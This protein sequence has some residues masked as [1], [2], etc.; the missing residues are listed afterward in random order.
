M[1][2]MEG[3]AQAVT[4]RY[5]DNGASGCGPI[6]TTYD[7]AT[8]SCGSGSA[9]VYST[10]GAALAVDA[11]GDVTLVRDGTYVESINNTI[12]SGQGPGLSNVTVLAGYGSER[13]II[14]PASYNPAFQ[15]CVLGLIGPVHSIVVEN[16]TFD[17]SGCTNSAPANT[18]LVVDASG[19]RP[20]YI[21]IHNIRIINTRAAS[22]ILADMDNSE[23]IDNFIYRNGDV[24]ATD[25]NFMGHGMY[26]HSGTGNLIS[27][28]LFQENAG[29]G[30][31]IYP[32]AT[33]TEVS[34]N[35]FLKNSQNTPYCGCSSI[36]SSGGSDYIHH[37][38]VD[39]IKGN[40]IVIEF[41]SVVKQNVR[42]DNNS[43]YCSASCVYGI[44]FAS[45]TGMMARNNIIL[46]NFSN[47]LF[48]G[49]TN[50]TIIANLVTGVATDIWVNPS[51]DNFTLKAASAAID[52]AT[53]IGFT[54]NGIACDQGAY[55][56]FVFLSCQVPNG[57]PSTIQ[58]T[59][60][61]DANPPLKGLTIFT[62]RRNGSS[63]ALTGAASLI[64]DNIVS[65]PVTTVYSIGNTADISWSSGM[66]SDSSP[67]G[68]SFTAIYQGFTTTLSNQSC[69]NNAGVGPAYTLAQANFELHGLIGSE[70]NPAIKPPGYL[71]GGPA[72]NYSPY[73]VVQS[74][75]I[76][77]RFEIVANNANVPAIGFYLYYSKDGAGYTNVPDA[78]GAD[79]IAFCGPITSQSG[80]VPIN[81]SPT[82]NQMAGLETFVPGGII[83]TA[84]AIPTIT[85]LN[86]GYKTELEYCVSWN[87]SATGSYKLRVYQQNGTPLD[88]YYND[89]T[90]NLIPMQAEA[91]W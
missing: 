79:G 56:S 36:Q 53:N 8:R 71:P 86:D 69:T 72:E 2:T 31:T 47:K 25:T 38:V 73:S 51:S 7:V 21:R 4:T 30:L 34:L 74:G 12:A 1:L 41:G 68:G 40:G 76:R 35:A 15:A 43:L 64:G 78:F 61:N 91:L 10:I 27:R 82:T 45:G 59:F 28:N 54:C 89:P 13:P 52:A 87:A 6:S 42:V 14:R 17:A 24:T 20:S 18:K 39:A 84:N 11:A 33:F 44:R 46:G 3:Q 22:G 50:S 63:N 55:E 83:F 75:K 9:Q 81:G 5:V 85:G 58:V 88:V 23:I 26:M 16:F 67:V 90:L 49:A 62:A 66:L 29:F 80:P 57:A 77:V 65:L 32:S 70:A 60:Q 37:N 48:N 19:N